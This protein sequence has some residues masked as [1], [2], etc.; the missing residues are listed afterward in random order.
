M[1]ERMHRTL[2]TVIISR[3]ESWLSALAIVLLGI[4]SIPNDSGF[5]PYTAVTG[6]QILLP[7]LL[8]SND[9]WHTFFQDSI[10]K[11]ADETTCLD[12][13][14]L[15][16]GKFVNKPP[17]HVPKDLNFVNTKSLQSI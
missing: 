1:V 6:S 16:Q 3:K 5:S 15:S 14:S 10:K 13:D 11:L 7:E 9:D 12:I 2:K 4:R 8:I 17:I